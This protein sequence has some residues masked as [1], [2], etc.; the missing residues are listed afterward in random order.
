ME[1]LCAK[2]ELVGIGR[3]LTAG[4]AF[5]VARYVAQMQFHAR[6]GRLEEI[7]AKSKRLPVHL[8]EFYLA[9][10][11]GAIPEIQKIPGK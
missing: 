2:A 9:H 6:K 8:Q 3:S 11:P 4:Q 7:Q 10:L 1:N 5:N